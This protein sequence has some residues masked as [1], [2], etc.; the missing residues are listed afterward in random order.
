MWYNY[1]LVIIFR[2]E[3]LKLWKKKLALRATYNNLIKA[4]EEAE[5][6]QYSET[7]RHLFFQREFKTANKINAHNFVS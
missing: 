3:V 5:H 6:K 4:F 7:V 2:R 1:L